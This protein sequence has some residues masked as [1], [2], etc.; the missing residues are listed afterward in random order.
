MRLIPYP[1]NQYPYWQF[2]AFDK[3]QHFLSFLPEADSGSDGAYTLMLDNIR[4]LILYKL[5][6]TQILA[7]AQ[8]VDPVMLH[9][10]QLT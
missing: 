1:N 4:D 5:I 10:Y 9:V 6:T 3:Y 7:G 8:V 2:F